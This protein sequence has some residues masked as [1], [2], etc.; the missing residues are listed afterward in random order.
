MAK[1]ATI[2]VSVRLVWWVKWYVAGVAA[3]SRATGLEPDWDRVTAWVMRG[4]KTEIVQ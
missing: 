3:M 1:Q 2:N 4:I